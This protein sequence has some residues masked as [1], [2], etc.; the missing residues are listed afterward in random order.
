MLRCLLA[1]F[2]LFGLLTLAGPAA[3]DPEGVGTVGEPDP[4]V[5]HGLDRLQTLLDGRGRSLD[6]ASNRSPWLGPDAFRQTRDPGTGRV[7]VSGGDARG[8]QYGL[9]DLADQLR[10]NGFDPSALDLRETTP[11]DNAF[12]GIKFNV[13]FSAY[14]SH[15]AITQHRETFRD[16][17]FWAAFLD[18]MAENRFNALSLWSLHP[19]T[20][21]VRP[22]AYP[23]SYASIPEAEHA[24]WHAFYT[25]LFAMAKARGIETY[26]VWWTIF[27]SPDYADHHGVAEYS[28]HLAFY[29]KGENDA[30]VDAY[31]RACVTALI[32]D[33]PD[34]TGVG[35][36]LGERIFHLEPAERQAWI[37]ANVVGGIR[38]ASR[39][40]KFIHRAPFTGDAA[41]TRAAVDALADEPN[42]TGP[43][44]M[45]YKFNASHGH[46]AVKLHR[47]HGAGV[48]DAYW[49]DGDDGEPPDHRMVWMMRNEDFTTLR[50][51]NVRFLRDHIAENTKPWSAGYFVGSETYVPAKAYQQKRPDD[52]ID[53][54][55]AFEREWLFYRAWGRLLYDPATDD[56]VFADAFAAR[57][58]LDT[59]TAA[60]LYAAVQTAGRVPLRIATFFA[61]NNDPSLTVEHFMDGGRS[62]FPYDGDRKDETL[63]INVDEFIVHETLNPAWLNVAAYAKRV[64]AGRPVLSHETTPPEVAD[65]ADRDADGVLAL[66]RSAEHDGP[67]SGAAA[68]EAIDARAWAHLS[69]YFADKIRGAV[70]LERFRLTGAPR[71]RADAVATL[72]AARD[73]W[74]D[75]VDATEA[76][77]DPLLSTKLIWL[78]DDGLLDWRMML[79]YVEADIVTARNAEPT[80]P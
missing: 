39:P 52:R 20:T 76:G 49:R 57:Y 17:T 18:M 73:H 51:T 16:L 22:A 13:P 9:L 34:L 6:V 48:N 65:A 68:F 67:L 53:W 47:T 64:A 41:L 63:F 7:T 80:P 2:L 27:V 32:D 4:V 5:R 45:E 37:N 38:D 43:V 10:L 50:W 69:R 29:G 8:T 61:G 56:A 30:G 42:I 71:H 31:N 35:V 1:V 70:A 28:K 46:S 11:P 23:E 33:Y 14:R 79:P 77:Y 26:V 55:Y 72:E 74:I 19:F 40:V 24:E 60:A 54:T 21:M 59:E 36:S 75:L 25:E 15:P 62:R 44:L 3:A 78:K 12:R 66:L 58:G